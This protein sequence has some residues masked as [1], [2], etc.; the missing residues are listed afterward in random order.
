MAHVLEDHLPRLILPGV[1]GAFM[2][3]L[4]LSIDDYIITFFN[5]GPTETFPLRVFD[6][7]RIA[8]P[9]QMH[10]LATMVMLVAITII[11]ASSLRRQAKT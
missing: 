6:S 5:A 1:A 11:L 4:A 10:V 9:P 3:S 8:L 2:L 7:S